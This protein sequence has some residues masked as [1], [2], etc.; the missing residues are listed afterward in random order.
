MRFNTFANL[1][2]LLTILLALNFGVQDRKLLLG[3]GAPTSGGGCAYTT[4]GTLSM[5]NKADAEAYNGAGFG[6]ATDG[7]T[8]QQWN[9]QSGN[10]RHA[11]QFNAGN[12]PIFRASQVNGL[13]AIEFDGTDDFLTG[14][15]SNLTQPNVLFVVAYENS[16]NVGH[17]FDGYDDGFGTVTRNLMGYISGNWCVFAG[18]I[19]QPTAVQQS[20]WKVR[21]AVFDGTSS[22]FL[23]NGTSY[24]TGNAGTQALDVQFVIGAGHGGAPY[25][26][27]YIAEYLFYDSLSDTNRA[28]VRDCLMARYGL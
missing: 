26:N 10:A 5:W 21:E 8:V 15:V 24:G 14:D 18:T 17:V 7:Q 9:D 19:W 11:S 27:G 13:P 20:A 12:R 16:A 1:A 4:L 28:T 2:S 25:F 6:L 23:V 3:V 22:K